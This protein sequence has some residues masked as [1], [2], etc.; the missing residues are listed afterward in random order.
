MDRRIFTV[1]EANEL[2]PLLDNIF[3]EMDRRKVQARHHHRK[4]QVLDTLWGEELLDASNPDH[5]EYQEHK[6]GLERS[7]KEIERLI[8]EEIQG[9]GLRFP[10]G[11]LEHGLID[12]PTTWQGRRVFLCWKHGEEEVGFWHELEGGYRGRQ[13][14]TEEQELYMGHKEP[15]ADGMD[16]RRT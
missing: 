6:R 5:E 9:R 3:K 14:I 10:A 12:F 2:V 15:D 4:M 16:P 1:E 8:E 11:G 7:I 13:E